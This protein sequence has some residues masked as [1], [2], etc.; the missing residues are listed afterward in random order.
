MIC[1]PECEKMSRKELSRLQLER[2]QAKIRRD[3]AYS[4]E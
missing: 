1:S 2:L 4:T 3:N